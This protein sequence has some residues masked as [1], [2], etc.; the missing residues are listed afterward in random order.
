VGNIPP[1]KPHPLNENSG[2]QSRLMDWKTGFARVV[3]VRRER[4]RERR[5][6]RYFLLV[7]PKRRLPNAHADLSGQW[8]HGLSKVCSLF[9]SRINN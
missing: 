3:L 6:G 1:V 5:M 7:K 4:P 9:S 8:I 2:P